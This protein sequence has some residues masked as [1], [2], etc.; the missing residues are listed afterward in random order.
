MI[1][2]KV[3]IL[4]ECLLT[5]SHVAITDYVYVFIHTSQWAALFS[6]FVACGH[7][8]VR[9]MTTIIVFLLAVRVLTL[10]FS[11]PSEL[12]IQSIG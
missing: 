1:F 4:I 6:F 11:C 9:T 7:F 8:I 12:P 3:S 2:S 10:S 5:I